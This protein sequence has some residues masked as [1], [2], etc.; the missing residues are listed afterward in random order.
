M[1]RLLVDS[2]LTI[3]LG[4]TA[5]Q[6]VRR[7]Q[8]GLQDA[9]HRADHLALDP[10]TPLAA[11]HAPAGLRAAQHTQSLPRSAPLHRPDDGG[12]DAPSV[13]RRRRR[14]RLAR[15]RQLAVAAGAIPEVERAT[16]PVA[17]QRTE[18]VIDGP[19]AD[20]LLVGMPRSFHYGNGMGSNPLLMMQAIGSSVARAKK[21]AA[22]GAGGDRHVGLRRLVQRRGVPRLPAGLRAAAAG[23]LGRRPD[24]VRGR[25]QLPIRSGPTATATSGPITRSTRSRCPTWAAWPG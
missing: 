12:G 7:L 13:L 20:V 18:V 1:N 25:D 2:D 16:W 8:R 5:G 6:P 9:G 15:V 22:A 14:P 4:H 21:R 19:P 23:E 17:G 10:R 3:V 11:D 24:A